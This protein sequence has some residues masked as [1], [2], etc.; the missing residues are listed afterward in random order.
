MG[1][2]IGWI[3]D[4]NPFRRK[5][6]DDVSVTIV[7]DPGLRLGDVK[8]IASGDVSGVDDAFKNHGAVKI[9]FTKRF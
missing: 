5:L 6:A 9:T 3:K 4:R 1:N 7:P 8:D 2:V